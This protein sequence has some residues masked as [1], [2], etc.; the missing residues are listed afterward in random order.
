MNLTEKEWL[1]DYIAG[2]M[3]LLGIIYAAIQKDWTVTLTC[4]NLLMWIVIA[5][6]R[7]QEVQLYR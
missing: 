3:V 1:L 4:V 6:L 5:H 2:V 7:L